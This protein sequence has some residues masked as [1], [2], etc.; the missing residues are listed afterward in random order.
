MKPKRL[1]RTGRHRKVRVLR[2]PL[3]DAEL[4]PLLGCVYR[5]LRKR[6]D[7][8][9]AELALRAGVGEVTLRDLEDVATGHLPKPLVEK[10]VAEALGYH[11]DEVRHLARRWRRR[12]MARLKRQRLQG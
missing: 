5:K 7:F 2:D 11:P 6:F 9:I 12:G 8:S 3:P 4:S 1:S 10:H